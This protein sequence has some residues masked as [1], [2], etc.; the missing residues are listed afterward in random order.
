MAQRAG[1]HPTAIVDPSA[2]LAEGV[3]VGAYAIIKGGVSIGPGSAILEHCVLEGPTVI[4]RGCRIGPGAYVGLGPQHLRFTPDEA[5]PTY[6]VIGDNVT[7]REGSRIHRATHPGREHATR[8]GDNCYLM[9][10]THVAHDCVLEDDVIMA[11]AALLGG[12]CHIGARA[13]LGGGC[14]L[15]QFVQIGR[16]TI[17]GGNEGIGHSV[18]PF[19]AVR[20]GHLKG[21]NAVGCRRAGMAREAIVAIRA[22]Y[23][24]LRD[25][26]TTPAALVAIRSEVPDLPE[27]R[28]IIEF[29]RSSRRGML[30]SFRSAQAGQRADGADEDSPAE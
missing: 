10:A 11:D 24:R 7:I 28:E 19:A 25:H 22:A 17:V 2:K 8:I 30:P 4:G 9:G 6:L 18:P 12:H 27:V 21:Y 1:V 3:T 16:L 20:Y 14:T 26:R 5:N 23:Q 13:F 29:I 15:H